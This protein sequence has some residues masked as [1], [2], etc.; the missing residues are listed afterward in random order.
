MCV[1]G[2]VQRAIGSDH[3]RHYPG[4]VRALLLCDSIASC[5]ISGR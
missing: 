3:L 1:A 5:S 4:S 2:S